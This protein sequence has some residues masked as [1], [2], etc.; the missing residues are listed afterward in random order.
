MENNI[1][2]IIVSVRGKVSGKYIFKVL[3]R[4]PLYEEGVKSG[5]LK[6]RFDR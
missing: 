6:I 4:D 1:F 3:F 2:T 5:S